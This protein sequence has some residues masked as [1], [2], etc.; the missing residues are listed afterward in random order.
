VETE[1]WSVDGWMERDG[2]SSHGGLG[3]CVMEGP[4]ERGL[5]R[6]E[7][8]GKGMWVEVVEEKWFFGVSK[9]GGVVGGCGGV[10]L[11]I[12]GG[13]GDGVFVWGV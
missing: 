6:G 8:V 13:K 2:L 7:A 11:R 9:I 5:G 10:E 12:G 3:R 4:T 1:K